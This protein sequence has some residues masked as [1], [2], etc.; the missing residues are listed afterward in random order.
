MRQTGSRA[1]VLC[2]LLGTSMLALGGAATAQVAGPP[3]PDAASQA[4]LKPIAADEIV[5][6]GTRLAERKAL[7]EKRAANNSVETLYAN[8]VGK[9]PDQNVAEAIRRLPGLS[10]ANDQG[11]G[12]YVIIRGINPNL[13]NVVLN[14][15]TLPAPEPD[16]R[17]V[18]LDDIP[19][20]L[21]SSVVVTKSLTPD[22][23]ANAI[24]GE[25]N[26]RT[27]SAFD[28]NKALFLDARGA[29][30]WYKLNHKQPWEADGQIGG[31]FGADKQFGAVLSINYSRRPIESE[32][33]Q[34]ST[35]FLANG[36]P[37]QYGLRDYNL[38]RTRLGAVANFDWHASDTVK[39]YL[40][41]SYSK[42]KD[43]ERRDQNRVDQIVYGPNA[44]LGLAA[45]Q[46]IGRGSI[47]IR[48][49]EEDDN[50]K[51]AQLGGSFD[52]DRAGKLDV[53]GAY[54]RAIKN[55]PLRSEY[56]FRA[57]S[58]TTGS[59][60]TLA[61]A[62]A[63]IRGSYDLSQSPYGF[64]FNT[65]YNPA[66]FPLN[67]VNYDRRH[68]QEDLWQIRGDYTLPVAIGDDSTIKA[69][70][71]YLNRHKT[72][73]RDYQQFSRGTTF[74][75]SSAT[76]LDDTS[77]YDGRYAFGPRIDYDA[78]QA[79]AAANPT[80]LTQ[81]AANINTSRNNSQIND[82]DVREKITAG[83]VMATLKFGQLTLVP[84][85]R[86]EHTSDN[87]QAKLIATGTAAADQPF[88]SFTGQSYTDV[89]PGLN[90][91]YDFSRNLILRGAVTTS[92]GRPNYPDLAPYVS[93]DTTTSPTTI[94][95]GNPALKRYKAV[96]LDGS[97]EYYL[98]SQGVLSIGVF[99]KHIDNPIYSQSLLGQS[100]T[101]GGQAFTGVS[102]TQAVNA[103]EATV[104]GIEI[105]AQVQFTFLPA[106][107]DGFG[108]SANYTR[109]GGHASGLPAR[110]GNIPLFLQSKNVGTAQLFFEKYGFAA[111]IAYS[112][113]SAYA[114]TLGA[115]SLTDQYSGYN[116][117][118][119][120]HASYQIMP[121]VTIFADGTNLN[122][123]PWRRY[124]GTK[125]FLIE[126][127]RYDFSLRGGVQLHF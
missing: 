32:N 89:F 87:Q 84:G 107:F 82:Y 16:G 27:L 23:D 46:Y 41:T 12:R 7:Q 65:P 96:N 110:A 6:T 98:P 72:N 111:R 5:V 29:Y 1:V 92:L 50:T 40:R 20:A 80:A 36:G 25:V 121:Q 86:I 19:S 4:D 63:A 116:G 14:G 26:I 13:V 126:R 9:L 57:A 75:A 77:F 30:G 28:R 67:S 120:V 90:A 88:N 127:E 8:D 103:D 24:G 74:N 62:P 15:L 61:I 81:S 39:L 113:R 123:A 83:Y 47:L 106:P 118:L 115:S 64:T 53:S 97:L 102:V 10:V 56:N 38:V 93:V 68:A 122:D 76:Y 71:K 42:F 34:G 58:P 125:A 33:F 112:F 59:G 31:L 104:K 17:Q 119:D 43:N 52:F 55:D 99:Y 37:D 114:D 109:I 108:V 44:Q 101:F 11:E 69:G 49:R 85:V 45:D 100:G 21:I 105:N 124:L 94:T 54:T 51:S 3:S 66:L 95:L 73:N 91:H 18:K 79:Y 117:Q 22:Q 48:R 70:A 78:A 2:A 35:A 60:A